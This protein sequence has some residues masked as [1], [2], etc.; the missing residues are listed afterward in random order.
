MFRLS[1]C[2]HAM[3]PRPLAAFALAALLAVVLGPTPI[4]A[5][6]ATSGIGRCT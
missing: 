6:P 4:T 3:S 5:A 2:D 1:I